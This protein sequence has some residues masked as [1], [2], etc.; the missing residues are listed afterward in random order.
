VQFCIVEW[1]CTLDDICISGWEGRKPRKV[2]V[3]VP[4][5]GPMIR[6]GGSRHATHI[7]VIARM[8]ATGESLTPYTDT[9]YSSSPFQDQ[10]RK[11]GVCFGQHLALKSNWSP[12]V[13]AEN[14]PDSIG[15]VCLL[16]LVAI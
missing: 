4:T 14:F 11:P 6:D 2:V 8:W 5:E 3:P 13:K 16:S 12:Y 9:A 10:V 15:T 1:V 7:S